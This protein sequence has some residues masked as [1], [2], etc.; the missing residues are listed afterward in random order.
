MC[1]SAGHERRGILSA[2]LPDRR[3]H[4]ADGPAAADAQ[5]ADARRGSRP[6]GAVAAAARRRRAWL[7]DQL[8]ARLAAARRGAP[9]RR[10]ATVRPPALYT[11]LF[12]SVGRVRR[13]SGAL[14]RQEPV[15]AAPEDPS[16]R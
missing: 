11:L 16:F 7:C 1:T 9:G 14:F 10:A 4:A 5:G 6:G 15:D 2:A 12:G 13:L 3:A 8:A